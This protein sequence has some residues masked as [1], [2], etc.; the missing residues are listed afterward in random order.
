MYTDGV[1]NGFYLFSGHCSFA[2][3]TDLN[4]IIHINQVRSPERHKP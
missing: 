4:V 3:R 2:C 1:I